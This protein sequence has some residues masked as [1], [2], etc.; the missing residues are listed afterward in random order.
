MTTPYTEMEKK[1]RI[2]IESRMPM[3][4]VAKK[5]GLSVERMAMH[6]VS[7]K[8]KLAAQQRKNNAE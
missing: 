5:L 4:E 8:R 6:S 7:Y 1:I 2:L 3:F